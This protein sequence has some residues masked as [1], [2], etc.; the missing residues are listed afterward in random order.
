MQTTTI[1]PE[2]FEEFF[3]MGSEESKSPFLKA[4]SRHWGKNLEVKSALLAAFF[5]LLSFILHFSLE[6]VPLSHVFLLGAYFFA[7]IPSLIDSV[8]DLLNFDINID[9]L[10]TLAAFASV[11]IGSPFE[12]ALLL[13]LFCVSGS[14]EEAVTSKARGAIKSLHKLSPKSASV[15]LEG[16]RLQAR[17]VKE[18]EVGTKILVKAGEIVPLDGLVVEGASSV[19]LVHLTGENF[20]LPKKIEDEVPAGARNLE[21]ALTLQVTHLSS[22]STLSKIIHLVTEAQEAKPQLQRFFD[23]ISRGYALTI[24]G[25][26][27]F[28]AII[29]PPLL[30]IPYLGYEGSI[31]RALSFLIAA[32]PCALIIAIPIAY[33]SA[34]SMC[35]KQGILLKG[36]VVLD[37]L[38]QCKIL[39]LDKTGTLTT[40]ALTLK[41]IEGEGNL[42]EILSIA[43]GLE[44]GAV[45]P[46]A[47]AVITSAEQKG[48]V[49]AKIT[50]FQSIPGYGLEGVYQEKALYIGLPERGFALLKQEQV[51]LL[52]EKIQAH[53]ENGELVSLLV[54]D[55]KSY[56]LRFL[57]TPRE[58]MKETL[59]ALKKNHDLKLIML[60]GDHV[61]NAKQVAERLA[62]D[63]YQADLRPEDKLASISKLARE[64]HLAM[65]GDGVN[66][67]PALAKATVGICMGKVGSATAMEASDIILL[68]DNIEKLDW[69][70]T[71][72]KETS[73]VVKQNLCIAITAILIASFSALG[74]LIPLWL[75]VVMH[76]GGTVLVGLNALRLLRR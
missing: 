22:D 24:M 59:K 13:V 76:E 39:A 5:L 28:F 2:I 15:V 47:E 51:A 55:Q 64:G 8:E 18:I 32:S 57:D 53:Q 58:G 17:S 40:G 43:Y 20:P 63:E 29:F 1:S 65:V 4:T 46:V 71:K 75:A 16:G 68:H 23:R 31:Y 72:A 6:A 26:T 19:N 70:F 67:A 10:M 14:M 36:G 33:L 25:L 37:A 52:K 49:A 66:D 50:S 12:G 44:R 38:A 35:A 3:D 48:L 41:E 30:A 27:A 69:L 60:T 45:H 73:T 56:L 54:F 9:V 11:L 62:I 7:G 74:G 34:V 61:E 21:G 42:E